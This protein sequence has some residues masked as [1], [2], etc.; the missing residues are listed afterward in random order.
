MSPFFVGVCVGFLLASF[1]FSLFD[2]VY[3]KRAKR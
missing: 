3:E 2:M 1:V